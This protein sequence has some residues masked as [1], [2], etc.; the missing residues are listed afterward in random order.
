MLHP[1]ALVV[2]HHCNVE[3]LV[4]LD[5]ELLVDFVSVAAALLAEEHGVVIGDCR[6]EVVRFVVGSARDDT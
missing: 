3:C 1:F 6:L 2:L 4:H 5:G